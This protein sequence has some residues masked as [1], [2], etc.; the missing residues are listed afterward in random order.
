MVKIIVGVF[1]HASVLVYPTVLA[2]RDGSE[3]EQY[4]LKNF[5][6]RDSNGEFLFIRN[7]DSLRKGQVGGAVDIVPHNPYGEHEEH[8]IPKVFIFVPLLAAWI[9]LVILVSHSTPQAAPVISAICRKISE[10]TRTW[11]E[12]TAAMQERNRQSMSGIHRRIKPSSKRKDRSQQIISSD[13]SISPSLIEIAN[14]ASDSDDG[15]P[16]KFDGQS[17]SSSFGRAKTV[18]VSNTNHRNV[19]R[20]PSPPR[21]SHPKLSSMHA[22]PRLR[23]SNDN[24]HDGDRNHQK[25]IGHDKKGGNHGNE[26]K[27]NIKHAN[28][29]HSYRPEVPYRGASDLDH[30]HVTSR[31]SLPH[32]HKTHNLT[33]LEKKLSAGSHKRSR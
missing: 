4:Y 21:E 29:Y 19:L 5:R 2:D 26:F 15:E 33:P 10:F 3:Q 17:T 7:R 20:D 18:V 22:L 32:K 1:L 31:D 8:S 23:Q 28:D 25:R 14:M 6:N 9:A 11:S 12:R 16:T 27:R 24:A 13:P 30:G